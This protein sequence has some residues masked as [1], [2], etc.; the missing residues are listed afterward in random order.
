MEAQ[1][2][3]TDHRASSDFPL[4]H[5]K[6]W[7]LE[8]DVHLLDQVPPVGVSQLLVVVGQLLLAFLAEV[9]EHHDLDFFRL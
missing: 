8:G 4:L 5:H 2:D 6:D 7:Q 9:V 1:Q 3:S